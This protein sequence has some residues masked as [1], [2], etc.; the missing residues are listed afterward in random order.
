[1]LQKACF[2][3]IKRLRFRLITRRAQALPLDDPR[4]MALRQQGRAATP[5][6]MCSPLVAPALGEVPSRGAALF[7]STAYG[8]GRARRR[9]DSQSRKQHAVLGG[10]VRPQ[11]SDGVRV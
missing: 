5:F 4:R 6:G 10:Q 2:D 11:A 8:F 3:G 9:Q 1:M 7:R